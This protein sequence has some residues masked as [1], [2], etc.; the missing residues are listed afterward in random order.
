M[1]NGYK[2]VEQRIFET[3]E[4]V[5]KRDIQYKDYFI[6]VRQADSYYIVGKDLTIF[7]LVFNKSIKN[8]FSFNSDEL[9][10]ILPS[11][12]RKSFRVAIVECE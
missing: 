8:I 3:A 10:H 2:S 9:N 4:N 12:V 1:I 6:I 5:V 11:L 7:N